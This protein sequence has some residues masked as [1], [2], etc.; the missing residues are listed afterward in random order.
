MPNSA[1]AGNAYFLAG[2]SIDAVHL[3]Y[4]I[5]VIVEELNGAPGTENARVA[6]LAWIAR[7][8]AQKLSTDIEILF[9]GA[10]E[11]GQ[12]QQRRPA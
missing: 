6:A 3:H 8:H 1:R 5:D 2:I 10:E 11:A 9:S 7:D 12:Y 4:L